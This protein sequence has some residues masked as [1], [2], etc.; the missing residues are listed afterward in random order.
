MYSGFGQDCLGT[1]EFSAGWGVGQSAESPVQAS[2]IPAPAEALVKLDL[3]DP[4]TVL[5]LKT[6]MGL[7]PFMLPLLFGD[8]AE[9]DFNESF[10]K[11]PIW[12]QTSTKFARLWIEQS[13]KFS[14]IPDPESLFVSPH[15][16]PA[17]AGVLVTLVTL[18]YRVPG[19]PTDF[20][21]LK[22]LTEFFDATGGDAA[23]GVVLAPYFSRE[24]KEEGGT[25]KLKAGTLAIAGLGLLGLTALFLFGG[26]RKK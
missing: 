14:S 19:N 16:F 4:E 6:A 7:T 9:A 10:F 20:N 5:Q 12:G 15:L 8:N 26:R 24:S 18:G 23:K 21:L 1:G 13:K 3:K 17:S 25:S 22:K 11:D 2:V